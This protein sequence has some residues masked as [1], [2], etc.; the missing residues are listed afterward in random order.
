MKTYQALV[1]GAGF[2]GTRIAIDLAEK[3]GLT[4]LVVI[5]KEG[6]LFQHAST[7]NQARVHSGLHYCRSLQTAWRSQ[8][9]YQRFVDDYADSCG[10]SF[11]S[12]YGVA[13]RN[14]KVSAGQ[15]K[16]FCGRLGVATQPATKEMRTLFDFDFIEDLFVVEEKVF[17]AVRLAAKMKA[18]LER[19]GVEV[20]TN[21]RVKKVRTDKNPY[22]VVC[23]DAQGQEQVLESALV[24]NCTYSG[25]EQIEGVAFKTPPDLKHQISELALIEVP[26]PLRALGVTIMDGPFF[27]LL[28]FPSRALHTLTHVRYTPH[29][30]WAAGSGDPYKKFSATDK[31]THYHRMMLD[32][33]RYMPQLQEARYVDSL[34]TIKTLLA[35]ND[36]DDGRPI[37]WEKNAERLYSILG[38]KIDNIY[39]VLAKLDQEELALEGEGAQ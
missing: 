27:S 6:D 23:E 13:K 10:R 18:D 17:D 37:F 12:L 30:R 8:V 25:L 9:N 11:T 1:I 33:K 34:W 14:S 22:Q 19:V 28:P 36:I 31:Q 2:Y 38:G 16:K 15:F 20:K 21:L 32:A 35:K 24:F 26:P 39:D 3:R 7:C 5:E 4:N 29:E